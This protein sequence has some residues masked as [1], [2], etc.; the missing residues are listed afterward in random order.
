VAGRV[1]GRCGLMEVGAQVRA[2]G[3]GDAGD[4]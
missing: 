1:A 2:E 4:R 3:H